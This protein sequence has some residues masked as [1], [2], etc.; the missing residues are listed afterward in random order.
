M[1]TISM[2]T[3]PAFKRAQPLPLL[4]ILPPP[5]AVSAAMGIPD[6]IP[7]H[8]DH[9]LQMTDLATCAMSVRQ[10]FNAPAAR[11]MSRIG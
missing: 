2:K 9:G 6:Y 7:S 11:L 10:G 3:N 4:P 5:R 1:K 8:G